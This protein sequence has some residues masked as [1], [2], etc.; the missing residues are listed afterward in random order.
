MP[1][2]SRD[3]TTNQK[4]YMEGHMSPA[5]Y[6]TEDDLVVHQWEERHFF[7]IILDAPV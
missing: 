5:A 7:L 4:A 1:R 3:Q 2:A 6:V